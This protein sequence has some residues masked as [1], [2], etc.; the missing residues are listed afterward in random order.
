MEGSKEDAPEVNQLT[1][2]LLEVRCRNWT[3]LEFWSRHLL[4]GHVVVTGLWHFWFPFKTYH[5]KVNIIYCWYA[6]VLLWLS[7]YSDELYYGVERRIN[8]RSIYLSID[9]CLL[10]FS[11]H[12]LW[13]NF[14]PDLLPHCI[15]VIIII[16][17][18]LFM[19]EIYFNVHCFATRTNFVISDYESNYCH[20]SILVYNE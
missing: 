13:F 12:R 2:F 16:G 11:R 1:A 3:W 4:H 15:V 5:E 17:C 19:R 18:R 20:I 8:V 7:C 6:R 14:P 9:W 10:S